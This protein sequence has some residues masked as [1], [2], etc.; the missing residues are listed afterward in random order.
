MKITCFKIAY[1]VVTLTILFESDPKWFLRFQNG[2]NIENLLPVWMNLGIQ[3]YT[4][5]YFP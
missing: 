1:D 4:Y 3:I 2:P 5:K